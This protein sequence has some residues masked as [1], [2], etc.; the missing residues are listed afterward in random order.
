LGHALTWP[1]RVIR[2]SHRGAG[3]H[4]DSS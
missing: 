4:P 2:R 3:G 1:A